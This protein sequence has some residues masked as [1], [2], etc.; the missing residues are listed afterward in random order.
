MSIQIMFVLNMLINI[1]KNF[2]LRLVNLVR[3]AH[4]A[5]QAQ[6]AI[7]DGSLHTHFV[8]VRT[9]PVW[10]LQMPPGANPPASSIFT[11]PYIS[12]K[13]F[14]S[15]E[16]IP[17]PGRKTC[18][19]TQAVFVQTSQVR[20]MRPPRPD[21]PDIPS[22]SCIASGASRTALFPSPASSALF[23]A[24]SV[25]QPSAPST[26]RLQASGVP[27]PNYLHWVPP[28]PLPHFQ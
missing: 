17:T 9:L 16:I 10:A 24:H 22:V 1:S 27:L 4:L 2:T 19:W 26:S 23:A 7:L 8:Q 14:H 18:V 3:L 6:I 11:Q 28:T 15:G 20:P 5:H 25:P 13:N 12:K 21:L